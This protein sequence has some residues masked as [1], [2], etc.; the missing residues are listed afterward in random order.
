MVGTV[1]KISLSHESNKI[2]MPALI[3]GLPIV[4]ALTV[5]ACLSGGVWR[6]LRFFRLPFLQMISDLIET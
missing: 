4:I 6:E 1:N 2:K 3:L 5:S